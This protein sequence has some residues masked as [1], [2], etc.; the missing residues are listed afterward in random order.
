MQGVDIDLLKLLLV[1]TLGVV[2]V[3]L[4]LMAVAAYLRGKK[5]SVAARPASEVGFVVDTFHELVSALKE[6]E[7][8]LEALRR[9]AEERAGKAEDYNENI[10]QSVPSGVISLDGAWRVVKVNSSAERILERRAGEIMGRDCRE[11]L[12]G[13]GEEPVERGEMQYMTGSGKRIWLGFS[14]TPLMDAG[15]R[16]IGRLLVFTDLTEL[17]ALESQAELR[18]RLSSLGEMAAG[19]A[20]ELRNPMG[21]ISG[22]VRLLSKKV[23]PSLSQT[24]EAITKEVSVMDRIVADFLSFARPRELSYAE[25]DLAALLKLCIDNV[26]AGPYDQRQPQVALESE[27]PVRIKGDEVLLRQAF[28]NLLQN[29]LEATGPEGRVS[30][31][32]ALRE[33]RQAVVTVSDT[34]H[35]IAEGIRDKVFLPFYTTKEKGTGL[36][37]AIVHRIITSHGGSIDL[38]STAQGTTFRIMLPIESK[39]QRKAKGQK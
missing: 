29:A 4:A 2:F 5:K 39:G 30:V 10:L 31:G 32:V 20:H 26:T 21:V 38:E 15:G 25:V 9:Q 3:L 13:L 6:K 14:L 1:A 8:E 22:Y 33:G 36:G 17:K 35:G 23:D 37:L 18:Q 34:G 16:T 24:V 27:G 7:K 19:I 11:L 28:T 12:G